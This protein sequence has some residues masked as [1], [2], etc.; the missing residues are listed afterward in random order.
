MEKIVEKMAHAPAL[1]YN[2]QDRGFIREGYYSDI[3]VIDND[4][5]WWVTKDNIL[6]KCGWAPFEGTEFSSRVSHTVINGTVAYDN[7]TFNEQ[8]R[9]KALAFN[10]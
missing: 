6:Y 9:G 8:Y 7:G 3:A 1:L 10:R 2:V 5:R 4:A